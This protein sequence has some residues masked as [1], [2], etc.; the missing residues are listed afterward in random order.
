MI[1]EPVNVETKNAH[2]FNYDKIEIKVMNIEFTD[3]LTSN[4]ESLN[5]E[6]V[7]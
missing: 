3:K 6:V 1:T 2:W 4:V 5:H 7:E